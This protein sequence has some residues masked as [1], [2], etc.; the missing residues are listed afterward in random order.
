MTVYHDW[1]ATGQL[2]IADA[3]YS[4]LKNWT[5]A[6]LVRNDTGL[7]TCKPCG[8]LSQVTD[9]D[10]K[11]SRSHPIFADDGKTYLGAKFDCTNVELDWPSSG[12][13]GFVFTSANTAV[14]A[15]VYRALLDFA[16]LAQALGRDADATRSRSLAERVQ[17]SIHA[18]NFDYERGTY[19]D[20]SAENTNHS[21]WHSN[22]F[23][24]AFGVADSLS[25][26]H[27]TA[28]WR[29]IVERCDAVNGV[30]G[31]VYMAQWVLEAMYMNESDYG[32]SALNLL[33][34][35]GK[36]SWVSML[37]QGATTTMEAWSPDEK[38]NLTFSHAWS[39][40]PAN[41]IAR[42]LF[43]ILPLSAGYEHVSIKPQIGDLKNAS[44]TL[45]SIRG[46]ISVAVTQT[47]LPDDARKASSYSMRVSI[48]GGSRAR[49]FVP[50]PRNPTGDHPCVLH[51]GLRTRSVISEQGAHLYV[52]VPSGT[53]AFSW[54]GES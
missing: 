52:D 24:Y 8:G 47:F 51:N 9:C 4:L 28:V 41:I 53:H 12:R 1:M 44:F 22:V 7:W 11:D 32:R 34:A 31:G 49:V 38:P 30:V 54:C 45:A 14:N 21:A 27:K 26:E 50:V 23:A 20:G 13:D 42:F 10:P 40:S 29:T 15:Y 37:R 18:R 25:S 6:E 17:K 3:H 19:L 35:T 46:P 33:R 39:G 16:S 5:L 2:D 36:N 48:P 43:G